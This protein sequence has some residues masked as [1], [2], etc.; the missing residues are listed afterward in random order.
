[1]FEIQD[2]TFPDYQGYVKVSSDSDLGMVTLRGDLSSQAMKDAMGFDVPERRKIVH[3]KDKS[4]GWMAPD[5]LLILCPKQNSTK[6]VSKLQSDLRIM[7]ALIVDVS[8]SRSVFVL[9]GPKVREVIAKLAP[10]AVA[11]GQF[12]PGEF[13]RSRFGQLA[14]TFWM[15]NREEVK[16]ICLRSFS[17]YMYELLCMSASKGSELDIWS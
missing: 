2:R 9:Q 12:G 17:T 15:T 13:R 7:H 14:T 10:V 4:I 6:I 11:P 16:I 3:Q 8:D 1:M 5:E